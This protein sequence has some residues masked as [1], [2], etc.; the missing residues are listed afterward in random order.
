MTAREVALA[1][2]RWAA[3]DAARRKRVEGLPT[4]PHIDGVAER[5]AMRTISWPGAKYRALDELLRWCPRVPFSRN[6]R[7]RSTGW[8]SAIRGSCCLR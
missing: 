6:S 5:R 2:I 7:G 1:Y 3:R 8:G 4:P